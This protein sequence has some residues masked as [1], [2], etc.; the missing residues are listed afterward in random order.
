FIVSANWTTARCVSDGPGMIQREPRGV[1][2]EDARAAGCT[3]VSFHRRHR[4]ADIP[5]GIIV[6]TEFGM[7]SYWEE[8]HFSASGSPWAAFPQSLLCNRRSLCRRTPQQARFVD[9]WPRYS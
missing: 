5:P 1:A 2:L 9:P 3:L 7:G 8:R 6:L 4:F